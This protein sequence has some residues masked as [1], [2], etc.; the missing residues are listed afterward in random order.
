MSSV[1][2]CNDPNHQECIPV[3]CVPSAAVG[4]SCHAHP[5]LAMHAPAT[6]APPS[7]CMPLAMHTPLPCTPPMPHTPPAIHA[8]CHTHPPASC[9]TCPPHTCPPPG[10]VC[11]SEQIAKIICRSHVSVI[12]STENEQTFQTSE[13]S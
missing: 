9:H 8:P 5:L 4:V 13:A 2:L 12:F 10:E 7:Q 6:C 1:R 11:L 3:G